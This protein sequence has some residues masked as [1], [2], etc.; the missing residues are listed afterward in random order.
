ME[1]GEVSEQGIDR[2]KGGEGLR[3]EQLLNIQGGS[4]DP[5]PSEVCDQR[6]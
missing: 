5:S 2:S 1:S 3:Q 4:K 6:A